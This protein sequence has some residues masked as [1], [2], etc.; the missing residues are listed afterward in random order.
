LALHVTSREEAKESL[1]IFPKVKTLVV[2]NGVTI[3]DRMEHHN[4]NGVL[5]L[6]YLGRLDPIKGIENLL[7]ACK[8]LINA[9]PMAWTLTIAGGGNSNYTQDLRNKIKELALSPN[10]K[11]IGVA[12]WDHKQELFK[13]TDVAVVPSYTENFAM[14]VAEAL[15]HGVPVIAS[16]GTPWKRLEEIGC[17]LWVDNDPRSLVE[18]IEQMSKMPL[19]DM[20]QRGREWIEREFNWPSVTEKMVQLYQNL[21]VDSQ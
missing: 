2:P 12:M 5:R 18:A 16:K 8:I 15:A 14:V 1:R 10:V 20:G 3:P 21:M 9:L 7:E 11:M 19:R 13:N 6:L 4:N 17:G